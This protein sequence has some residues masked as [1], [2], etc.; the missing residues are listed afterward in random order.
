MNPYANRSN[1]VYRAS[2]VLSI[3][4]KKVVAIA[5]ENAYS[6]L[7][8]ELKGKEGRTNIYKLANARKIWQR[9]LEE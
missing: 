9:T 8:E 6:Q 2:N 5:K 3:L 4:S 7:Y 1:L